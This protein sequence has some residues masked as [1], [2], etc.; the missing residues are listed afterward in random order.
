MISSLTEMKHEI[1]KKKKVFHCDRD[2]AFSKSQRNDID[3]TCHRLL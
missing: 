1:T 2:E 3:I